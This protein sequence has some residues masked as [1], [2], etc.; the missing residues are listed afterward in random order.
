MADT[1]PESANTFDAKRFLASQTRAPGVYQ[2]FNSAGDILYVGKAKNLKS[3]LSSYFRASG[4]SPKTAAL[5]SRIARVEV[6]VTGSETEA[7]ILEQNLI[8]A[9]RP[10]YNILLR[11]DKSYP[12]VFMSSG[13]PY[14]RISVHRGAKKKRGDYYGPYPN[15]GAV[16]DSLSFLQKTFKVRQC[17]DSVFRNRSRPCLQY[18]IDRC[19]GPCVDLISPDDYARDVQHTRMFLL[20]KSDQLM[21]E[22]ADEMERAA[23]AQEYERAAEVRDQISALRT[24]QSQ[25][26]VEESS[27]DMDIIAAAVKSATAC[28]HVLFIRQGRILGSRS[29]YPKLGLAE[30]EA[31]VLSEFLP[32]FY[33][34][35]SR[36]IPAAIVTDCELLEREL[37]INALAES[38]GARVHITH[39]V[40]THRAR[41]VDM[42]RQAAEQNIIAR[43]NSRKSV[44]DRLLALQ[45][46]L[47]LD[48]MPSRMECFDISHSSGELT[49]ASCV[50]FDKEGP[51]KSDYR[52][53]NID[54]ITGGDDY[55]AMSQA[56][57]RRYTRLQKGEGKLPDILFIDGGK[58]QLGVA[59]KVMAELGVNNVLLIGVAK[60]TTRKAGFET[61][62]HSGTGKE[63]VLGSDS[64]ALHVIQHIRDEAHRFAITGHKNRR[65]K[66]R[67]TSSLEGIPG[68]GAT[69]RRELL[70]HFGGLQDIQRASVDDLARV[71]GLSRKLAEDIYGYFH[72]D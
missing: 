31:D 22:L 9:N 62:Y 7:L 47:G 58:G 6:T 17:E 32:Q 49:V 52:R 27:G 36:D 25:Q 45:D 1:P 29:Y 23:L 48:E 65:D 51:A 18:Q 30:S 39:K 11:D 35:G 70:R 43:I 54:G 10:P 12:Y 8:K 13:E 26:S 69:R 71:N 59:E 41:W 55:A 42:A 38:R 66:K 72:P 64:P 15:V 19:T 24:V 67:K 61:L 60:G 16:K 50:V 56:L 37:L 21:S 20:G 2:M 57:T 53:F 46:V 63:I 40:R 5:V 14:P 4:L 34:G 68:V 44:T 33:L 28:V 3:R